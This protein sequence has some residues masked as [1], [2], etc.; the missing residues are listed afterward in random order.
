[1]NTLAGGTSTEDARERRARN[2][3]VVDYAKARD[4]VRKYIN[5]A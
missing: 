1:L 4:M 3:S 2:F 5:G